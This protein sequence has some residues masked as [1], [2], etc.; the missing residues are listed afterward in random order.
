[1]H[2]LASTPTVAWAEW[3]RHQEIH[4]PGDLSGVA[5]ALWAVLIPADWANQDLQAA[6]LAM[7]QLLDTTVAG[8]SA[9]LAL[10]EQLKQQGALG[11]LAARPS[12]RR[13]TG[14]VSAVT[15]LLIRCHKRDVPLPQELTADLT[16]QTLL[17]R[18]PLRGRLRPHRQEEVG[19]LLLEL[20]KTS[21][22]VCNASACTSTPS[23]SSW[24]IS[25]LRSARS[26][27]SP[28]A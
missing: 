6:P 19:P 4:V 10:V 26:W 11:L 12:N 7:D 1:M 2:V 20:S 28:V 22:W 23:R 13:R 14:D 17:I 8:Q 25:C 16:M 3:I 15:F 5:A 24:A 27:F 18:S 9:R 21:C